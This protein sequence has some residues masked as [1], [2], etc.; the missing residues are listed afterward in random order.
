MITRLF[1]KRKIRADRCS[2]D[3]HE[4]IQTSTVLKS[5]PKVPNIMD[6]LLNSCKVL[7]CTLEQTC[8]EN[9][10]GQIVLRG[11]RRKG[12]QHVEPSWKY[13]AGSQILCSSLTA[14]SDIELLL[15]LLILHTDVGLVLFI[16]L[17]F[18]FTFHAGIGYA[19]ETE[20]NHHFHNLSL[21]M[22]LRCRY[23]NLLVLPNRVSWLNRKLG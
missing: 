3:M 1:L 15:E 17:M 13:H 16:L 9:I 14:F 2:S 20:I 8:P 4:P 5:K 22:D 12:N 11:G 21:K 7:R 19:N 10:N 23:E 18:K 6:R